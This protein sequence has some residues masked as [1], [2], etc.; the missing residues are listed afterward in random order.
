[1]R[2][3]DWSSDVCS[4]DLTLVAGPEA[5]STRIDLILAS[6]AKQAHQNG[7]TV[8]VLPNSSTASDTAGGRQHCH[9]MA[10]PDETLAERFLRLHGPGRAEDCLA[11]ERIAATLSDR[12]HGPATRPAPAISFIVAVAQITIPTYPLA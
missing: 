5:I 12:L 11:S 8:A 6:L 10:K 2:I 7:K 1:M 3:S 4:S 9:D